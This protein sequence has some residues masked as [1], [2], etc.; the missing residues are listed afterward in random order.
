VASWPK[1]SAVAWS[2]KPTQIARIPPNQTG[3][4]SRLQIG[5]SSRRDDALIEFATM[6]AGDASA[7]YY[8]R[9]N[10]AG[11]DSAYIDKLFTPFQRLHTP[12]EF[13]GTGIGLA[14]LRQI[15]ERHGGHV[16][17]EGA[18]GEGA[19]FYFTLDAKEN[20]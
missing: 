13:P 8:V 17:A 2:R 20:A 4:C 7:C 14:S 9:D 18:V 10:G 12:A 5:R 6:P 15:V 19:T 16:W 1:P 11:F 3:S